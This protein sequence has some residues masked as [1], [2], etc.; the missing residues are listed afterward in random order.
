[1]TLVVLVLLACSSSLLIEI[2]WKTLC[3]PRGLVQRLTSRLPPPSRAG[4]SKDGLQ[5][6]SASL[7]APYF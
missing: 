5:E 7:S 2:C 1:M 4:A 6:V 3:A